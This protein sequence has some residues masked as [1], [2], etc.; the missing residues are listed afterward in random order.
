MSDIDTAM[1]FVSVLI[2]LSF[3]II[4]SSNYFSTQTGF[5]RVADLKKSSS[6]LSTQLFQTFDN[7]LIDNAKE[8][9]ILFK[10]DLGIG[11]TETLQVSIEPIVN[12]IKVYDKFLNEIPSTTLPSGGKVIV[13]F[14]LSFTANEEKRIDIFYFGGKTTNIEYLSGLTGISARILSE[15]ET[16]LVTQ[17]RCNS[18]KLDYNKTRDDLGFEEQFRTDLTDCS[19]GPNPPEANV[20]LSSSPVLIE[21]ANGLLSAEIAR[22]SVW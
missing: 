7:S 18:L 22:I 17:D 4:Y 8:I 12:K 11:H 6:F 10:E 14:T 1:A 15:K 21:K 13:T 16:S 3:V 5:L 9:Q 20:I 19:F 2:I